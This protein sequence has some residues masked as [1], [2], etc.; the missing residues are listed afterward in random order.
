LFLDKWGWL[1]NG[2]SSLPLSVCRLFRHLTKHF[3]VNPL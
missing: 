2:K 3:S 1:H